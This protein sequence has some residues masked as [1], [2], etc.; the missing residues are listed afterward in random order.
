LGEKFKRKG[1]ALLKRGRKML[2]GVLSRD[3]LRVG[4]EGQI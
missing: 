1:G 3:E 4:L 2:R